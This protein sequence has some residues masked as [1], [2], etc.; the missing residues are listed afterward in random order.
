MRIARLV[1]LGRLDRYVGGLFIAS[2]ATAL[3]LVVGLALIIDIS[4]HLSYFEVWDDGRSASS[5]TLLRYYAL[6]LPFLY[7]RV[8]PFVTVTAGLF[9][10][11][12]LLKRNEL[13]AAL[14]AGVSAH[15]LL[16]PVFMGGFVAAVAMFGLRELASTHLGPKRD[17]LFEI[18]EHQR[19]ERVIENFWLRDIAGNVVRLG[20]F[21]PAVSSPPIAEIRRLEATVRIGGTITAI[22]A[23]RAVYATDGVRVGWRLEGGV[24]EEIGQSAKRRPIEWLEVIDFSPQDVLT[25]EKSHKG[26]ELELS[27]AEVLELARRDPDN[28]KY[29]TL[30]Q[31]HLTFPLAN[32]VLLWVVIP[33]LLGRERGHG[34]EGLVLA[35]LMCVAY[36]CV[37]FVTRSLGLDGSLSPLLSC[38][39]PVLFFGSLGVAL[40]AGMRT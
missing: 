7:L 20:E 4:T 30:M 23:D 26:R 1:A 14:S 12:R 19:T 5:G 22:R 2:Y 10:V 11:S 3:L 29:Q 13:V 37:D 15:R 25:A 28:I 33:F 40:V 38:W 8:A 27:M 39:L 36:F 32:V 9:T 35:C 21:R 24:I 34:V 16:T 31:Y 18:L 17:A 6:S